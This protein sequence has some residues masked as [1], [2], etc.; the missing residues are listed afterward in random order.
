MKPADPLAP[1]APGPTTAA[2]RRVEASV[3]AIL[4]LASVT[5]LYAAVRVAQAILFPEPNPALIVW[6]TR[7]ALFWR[8]GLVVYAS[9]MLVPMAL[10]WARRDLVGACRAAAWAIPVA[11]AALAFQS[12][13]FP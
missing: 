6:S 1:V 10:R 11:A 4:A 2:S 13:V 3:A 12:A 5:F 8:I 9:L 7:I